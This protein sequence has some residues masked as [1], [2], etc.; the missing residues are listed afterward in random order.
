VYKDKIKI[1][2]ETSRYKTFD[3]KMLFLKSSYRCSRNVEWCNSQVLLESFN[4]GPMT[5]DE[6]MNV[7][8]VDQASIII[9]QYFSDPASPLKRDKKI[10]EKWKHED[11]AQYEIA[12]NHITEVRNYLNTNKFSVYR[13]K[14][15]AKT[16][17]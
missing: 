11:A 13:A 14:W 17:A 7:D 16:K 9:T 15:E 2:E 5:M 8:Y 6:I 3:E 12:R 4:I 1:G 10:L